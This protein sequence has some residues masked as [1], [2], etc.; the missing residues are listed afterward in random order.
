M[1]DNPESYQR[2]QNAHPEIQQLVSKNNDKL[3]TS[4]KQ[5]T[6]L[7]CGKALTTQWQDAYCSL[8]M[9]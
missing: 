4:V 8:K 9:L 6:C 2:W 1:F 3:N 5:E 7:Y